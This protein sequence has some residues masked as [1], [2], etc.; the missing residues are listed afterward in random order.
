MLQ[1]VQ[2]VVQVDEQRVNCINTDPHVVIQF[3]NE[4]AK[5]TAGNVAAL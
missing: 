2:I 1:C 3:I 4:Q 5:K